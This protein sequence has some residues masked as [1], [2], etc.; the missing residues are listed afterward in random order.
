MRHA[1]A[2]CNAVGGAFKFLTA[3]NRLAPLP[4][5]DTDGGVSVFAVFVSELVALGFCVFCA[6]ESV[7]G[8]LERDPYDDS[9]SY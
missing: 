6:G 3:A 5:E 4:Y 7:R 1:S 2:A 8:C 9:V